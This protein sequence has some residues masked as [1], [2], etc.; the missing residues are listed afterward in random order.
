MRSG[1]GYCVTA[2]V[3]L[4]LKEF[5]LVVIDSGHVILYAFKSISLQ[6]KKNYLSL[7]IL[8]FPFY[9]LIVETQLCNGIL[10]FLLNSLM[11]INSSLKVRLI[12]KI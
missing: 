12:C 1:G 4:S 6:E 10:F 8:S 11:T 5:F 7:T 2:T 3:C 9:Y